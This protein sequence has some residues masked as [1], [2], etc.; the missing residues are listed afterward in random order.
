MY[1]KRKANVGLR[2]QHCL[3]KGGCHQRTK[4]YDAP[5]YKKCWDVLMDF[6]LFSVPVA[7]GKGQKVGVKGGSPD[8]CPLIF[9]PGAEQM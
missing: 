7:R 9:G 3:H 4:I 5:C 6:V 1:Q 8:E 2:C